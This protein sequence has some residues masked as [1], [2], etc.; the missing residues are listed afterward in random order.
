MKRRS[1]LS[2]SALSAVPVVAKAAELEPDWRKTINFDVLKFRAV[3]EDGKITLDV[4]LFRPAEDELTKTK[5]AEV[6][7]RY[8]YK[9]KL[10]PYPFQPGVNLLKRFDLTWDGKD[11]NIPER[12][13][14]DL[15]CLRIETSKL[16]PE[17]VPPELH[18]KATEFLEDLLQP[19]LSLSAEGGTVLIE[20]QRPEECDSLSTIRWIVSKS[21]VVLR[22]RD[23]LPHEC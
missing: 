14:N 6:P 15:A 16:D 18:L 4:E 20:W 2:L 7:F 5:D 9:G 1:F 19:R 13:W 23:F 11:M 17:K 10:L 3:G 22:H 8:A 12:F 21:G